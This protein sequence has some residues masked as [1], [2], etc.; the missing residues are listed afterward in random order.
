MCQNM[1]TDKVCSYEKNVKRVTESNGWMVHKTF[2]YSILIKDDGK[3][4]DKDG[5]SDLDND[6]GL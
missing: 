6:F 4:D 3:S 1:P 5:V 2:V